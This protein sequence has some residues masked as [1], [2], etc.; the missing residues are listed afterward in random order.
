[1]KLKRLN[2]IALRKCYSVAAITYNDAQHIV[3]AAE[4]KDKCLLFD[5]N[6]KL[7]DTIWDQP[8][9]TMSLAPVPG[10]NGMFLASQQMYA[11]D[12]AENAKIV[13]VKPGLRNKWDIKT[14]VEIPFVHRFGIL[15]R[16]ER[17][18]LVAATI[19]SSSEYEEDWRDPGKLLVCELPGNIESCCGKLT[20]TVLKD[21]LLKNHGFLQRHTADGDFCVIS[22]SEGVFKVSPPSGAGSSWCIKL[23]TSDPVSD[24]AFVDFDGD[25]REEMIT[26]SPFHGDS[27]SIYKQTDDQYRC[28]Y[29]FPE[30]FEFVHSLWAGMLYGKPYAVVGHRKGASRDIIGITYADDCYRYEV[31]VRDVGSANVLVYKNGNDEC[32]V[33]A[34]REIDEIAFYK[35]EPSV[36]FG[37]KKYSLGMYEKA[38]PS[39]LSWKEK[40]LTA[41]HCGYDFFEL[42][43]DETEEKLAR[44]DWTA[45]ER[46]DLFETMNETGLPIRSLCLS[47][48]RKYPL[49]SNDPAIVK[50]SLEIMEKAIH[51]AD[52]L[53]IR[54]IMLAGYDVYYEKSDTATQTRFAVNL[55]KCVNMAARAGVTLAFETMETP[56]MNTVGKA[57]NYVRTVNS[58][59]L[60]VYPD[61]GNI[62]NAAMAEG[63]N[64]LDDLAGCRGNIVSMHLK[65]TVPGKFRDLMYGQG[66]VDFSSAIDLAWDMGV[67]R[68]VTEFWYTGN[69][70]WRK[71]VQF[72]HDFA[73]EIL[74]RKR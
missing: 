36:T 40:L 10:E 41:R 44:L 16:G 34:N 29:T 26:L 47:G 42:S 21:G 53:G 38:V 35:F 14:L 30:R 69:P 46:M 6:G 59:Y 64:V 54:M 61:I 71:D 4:K 57:M 60:Q 66:D 11:P 58:A 49:G 73:A 5:L 33:S 7:E 19:K 51:L 8:G 31:L 27:I 45:E 65:E 56:F 22:A 32:M 23:L 48:H 74:D 18:Y 43:V 25:G 20:M 39:D 68:Y 13:L 52:D 15:I 3:V 37:E 72:A 9:G 1:M 50:R 24:A 67:R 28:I 55:E 70:L 62:T 12:E 63:K 17:R 2:T